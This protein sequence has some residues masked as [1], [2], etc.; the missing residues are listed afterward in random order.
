MPEALLEHD[1]ASRLPRSVVAIS[2]LVVGMVLVVG[3]LL[4]L[5]RR[6]SARAAQLVAAPGA[7]E[8]APEKLPSVC[9][10]L[11]RGTDKFLGTSSCA[12][13]SCHGGTGPRGTP[14]S[15][16]TTW[17]SCDPHARAYQVLFSQRS[18]QMWRLYRGF[19][20][21][22]LAE[23][24]N[25]ALCLKCHALQV[26]AGRQGH[27]PY[28]PVR[29]D[30]VSCES[31]HGPSQNW[32]TVHYLPEWQ[33]R[34]PAQKALDGLWPTKCLTFRVMLCATCH[35]GQ[36]GQEVNHDLI[37]AGHPALRFEYT[38]FDHLLPKH[39]PAENG[40]GNEDFDVRA[41]IIGQVASLRCA[42]DLLQSRAA[43]ANRG[44]W[45]EFA[46]YSC[47]SCH[48]Q[49]L[50]DKRQGPPPPGRVLGGFTWNPWYP[51]MIEKLLD[52]DNILAEHAPAGLKEVLDRLTKA[53]N[54]PKADESVVATEAKAC[55]E[56]LD[57]WLKALEGWSLSQP[58]TIPPAPPRIPAARARRLLESVLGLTKDEK[59]ASAW[60][61]ETAAQNF[62]AVA[63]LRPRN[64]GHGEPLADP[65]L[66]HLQ[67]MRGHLVFPSG[68]DFP[69]DFT[70]QQFL[71]DLRKV[72]ETLPR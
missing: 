11:A 64:N 59:Q 67:K 54:K 13:A 38:A 34:H 65:L 31:C 36:E 48:R 2:F 62:L 9:G 26:P 69:R 10:F 27:P 6:T 42:L 4:V 46:E 25:D 18:Q 16:L 60:E 47:F 58:C 24:Q 55:V 52:T 45:P 29:A 19:D 50:K 61:W 66:F 44:P 8:L 56:L 43:H 21:D 28:R 41:W 49:I 33:H 20:K 5:P 22:R 7:T 72:R 30:G 3:V 12:A 51:A 68:Y 39:W 71:N 32:R 40:P 63:A 1:V 17:A 70:T 53:M 57:Q 35:V 23:P 37:A 14:G 15:E